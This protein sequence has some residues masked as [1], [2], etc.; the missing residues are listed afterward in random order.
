MTAFLLAVAE[1][2]KAAAWPGL[3]LFVLLR[4]QKQILALVA[5]IREFPGTKFDPP[6][7]QLAEINITTVPSAVAQPGEAPHA[8][9]T[10]AA[11]LARLET[12]T[13][14]GAERNLM[15]SPELDGAT[16]TEKVQVLSRAAATLVVIASFERTDSGIWASQLRLLEYLNGRAAGATK[17]DLKLR[18]YDVAV[19]EFPNWF[20][21]YP[22]DAYLDFLLSP[23]LITNPAGTETIL[24]TD[25]GLEYLRW[26][27]NYRRPVK[28]FG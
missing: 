5:R 13:I 8:Q 4:H 2:L 23:G 21:G 28:A 17:D 20:E 10:R 6:P 19:A 24:I 9:L 26:R 12:P 25:A 22:F 16:D 27:I 18:F 7:P 1:I 14:L 11:W 15:A 3:V